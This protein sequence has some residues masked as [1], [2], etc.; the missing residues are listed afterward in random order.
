MKRA[1]F[2]LIELL[3]VIAIIAMLAA[4]LLP[5]LSRAK[6]KA[7]QIT[8]LNNLKQLTAGWYLYIDDNNDRLALNNPVGTLPDSSWITGSMTDSTEATNSYL[9]QIGQLW[10]YLKS[11]SAYRCPSDQSM[12]DNGPKVRS[13]SLNGQFGSTHD[14]EAAPW[15]SQLE[16]M[17][18]PGYPPSMKLTQITKPS[19]ALALAF[20]DESELTIDDGF[21]L[22]CLPKID[23]TPN[24]E[25]G[26]L[27]AF[28]RHNN[29]GTSFSFADGHSELW[30]WLDPR[31]TDPATRLNDV[32][33]GNRDIRRLQMAYAIP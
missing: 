6:G 2:T 22:I 14:T 8:C 33:P 17:S 11:L 9:L 27:P 5:A 25:W 21:F 16:A 32:Q 7:Q 31:T 26:N 12:A 1:G 18:N 19:P 3:V 29:N 30:K 15:D 20:A 10:P 28:R 13:Y 24:D 4:M 23:G